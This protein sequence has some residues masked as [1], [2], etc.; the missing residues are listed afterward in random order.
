MRLL[1][2]LFMALALSTSLIA[3]QQSETRPVLITGATID[4]EQINPVP[5]VSVY[6]KG[7]RYGTISDNNGYFSLYAS[8]GD[9]I[10]FRSVGY[11]TDEFALPT[12]LTEGTF[13]LIHLMVGENV[14]LEEIVVQPFP[15]AEEFMR[16]ILNLQLTA[17]MQRRSLE[18]Q[19]RIERNV[20]TQFKAENVY[21]DQWRYNKLYD[22]TGMSMPNNFINP[23]QWANFIRDWKAGVYKNAAP[24]H[25]I[26]RD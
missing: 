20:R 9:T 23:M 22:M 1:F 16:A 3:Q 2:S 4:V 11:Q 18:A 10:V 14:V 21:Y 8:A 7:S 15:T 25:L 6:I 26:K 17:D 13:S 24:G 12:E 5:F 19:E